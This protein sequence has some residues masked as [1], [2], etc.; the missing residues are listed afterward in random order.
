MTGF[1]LGAWA[2]SDGGM[3]ISAKAIRMG[4]DGRLTTYRTESGKLM[5]RAQAGLLCSDVP[6]MASMCGDELGCNGRWLCLTRS[7]EMLMITSD[8]EPDFTSKV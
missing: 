6:V 5:C 3:P 8:F 7:I 4:G 1:D 2:P